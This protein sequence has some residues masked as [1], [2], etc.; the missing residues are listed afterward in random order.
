MFKLLALIIFSLKYKS[1]TMSNDNYEEIS[2]VLDMG[3]VIKFEHTFETIGTISTEN[4]INAICIEN[5][6]I[7]Y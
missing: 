1:T 4:I 7:F 6:T 5:F 3:I 2:F